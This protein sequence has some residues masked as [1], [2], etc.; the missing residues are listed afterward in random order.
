MPPKRQVSVAHVLDEPESFPCHQRLEHANS[1][2]LGHSSG[3]RALPDPVEHFPYPEGK[4][5]RKLSLKARKNSL[6]V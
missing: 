6:A 3:A 5:E 1:T 4:D 2:D